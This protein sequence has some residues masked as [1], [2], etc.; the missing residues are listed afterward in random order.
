MARICVV[1]VGW[2]SARLIFTSN[3]WLMKTDTKR[4]RGRKHGWWMERWPV[5]GSLSNAHRTADWSGSWA[6]TLSAAMLA[7]S[8]ATPSLQTGGDTDV[9]IPTAVNNIDR[10]GRSDSRVIMMA[11]GAV[12]E[13]AQAMATGTTIERLSGKQTV[14]RVRPVP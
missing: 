12:S 9:Q 3:L 8:V 13:N 7:R 10:R 2:L 5:C 14:L 1:F 6:G 4:T 11:A